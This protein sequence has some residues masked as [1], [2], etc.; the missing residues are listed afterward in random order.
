V[1]K[2]GLAAARFGFE[3]AGLSRMNPFGRRDREML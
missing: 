2:I 1:G 3:I